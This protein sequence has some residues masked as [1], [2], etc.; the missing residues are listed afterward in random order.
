[1]QEQPIPQDSHADE[2]T[3]RLVRIEDQLIKLASSN[4]T[5][6][7]LDKK[8]LAAHYSC[9]V[10][11]IE[12]TLAEGMPHAVIYGRAKF[13]VSEVEPWLEEHGGFERDD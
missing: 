5:E 4:G 1:M 11:S 13:K 2:I 9:S 6:P 12:R 3:A 10:R 7:W 8:K